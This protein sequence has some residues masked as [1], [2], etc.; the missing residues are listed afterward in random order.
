M[1]GSLAVSKTILLDI[2]QHLARLQASMDIL[3]EDRGR[4]AVSRDRIHEKLDDANHRLAKVEATAERIAPLV[5]QLETIRIERAGL[6]RFLANTHTRTV[7]G[8]TAGFAVWHQWDTIRD[9][10]VKLFR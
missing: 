7:A 4:A 5:D 8:A 3:M 2:V 10:I 9:W 1:P 6:W